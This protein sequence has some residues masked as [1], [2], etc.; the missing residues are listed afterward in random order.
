MTYGLCGY[1]YRDALLFI[2]HPTL[3]VFIIT[4][5]KSIGLTKIT[6]QIRLKIAMYEMD[7]LICVNDHRVVVLSERYQTD[8]GIIPESLNL[9]GLY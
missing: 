2:L 4:N 3:L 7:I 9:M 8:K 6:N 1:N 5:L